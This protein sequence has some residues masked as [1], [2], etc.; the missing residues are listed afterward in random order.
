LAH[1]LQWKEEAVAQREK[2]TR[3]DPIDIYMAKEAVKGMHRRFMEQGPQLK[4]AL[5]MAYRIM[6]GE[7]MEPIKGDHPIYWE[8][9]K[10]LGE[11]ILEK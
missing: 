6:E 1:R 11:E 8:I 5:A 2:E 4:N 9:R 7:V 3:S 10:D